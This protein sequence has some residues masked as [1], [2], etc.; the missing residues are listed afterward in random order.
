MIQH[1]CVTLVPLFNYLSEDEQIK[2]NRLAQHKQFKKNEIVFRPGDENLDIVALGSMKVFQ[3]STNGDE[4]LLRVVEPGGYEGENQL[5]GIKNES[6]FGKTLETTEICRLSKQDFDQVML[7]NPQIALKLFELSAQKMIQ[8]EKQ[9]HIL[10]MERVEERL[11][12]YLLDLSKAAND[13]RFSLP[14]KMID[15]AR[16]IGTTPETLSRKFRFLEDNRLIKRSGRRII[17]L[18][19]DGLIDL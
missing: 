17:I 6:L 7:R 3:L 1:I 8:V 18:N 16:Y 11:A 13:Y 19:R 12:N 10:S 2:I 9:A 4:Q 5:F 14:M 15:I